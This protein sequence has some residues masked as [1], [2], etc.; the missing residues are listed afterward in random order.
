MDPI[1]GML[2]AAGLGG[3]AAPAAA[4]GAAGSTGGISGLLSSLGKIAPTAMAAGS[5]MS[6]NQKLSQI[7]GLGSL[8]TGGMQSLV[9][10]QSPMGN[11]AEI[12]KQAG[13]AGATGAKPISTPTLAQAIPPQQAAS[14][15]GNLFETQEALRKLIYGNQVAGLNRQEGLDYLKNT[16]GIENMMLPGFQQKPTI[17]PGTGITTYP[18]GIDRA[19]ADDWIFK[20]AMSLITDPEGYKKQYQPI[21]GMA[22]GGLGGMW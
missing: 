8:L 6:P 5:V 14:G 12:M 17:E 13:A 3:A 21:G 2:G 20:T 15:V 7:L 18:Y 22:L 9:P 1:T 19:A 4:A 10:Q 16:Y 11:S